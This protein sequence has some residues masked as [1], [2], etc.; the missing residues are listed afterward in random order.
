MTIKIALLG[1]WVAVLSGVALYPLVSLFSRIRSRYGGKSEKNRR[2]GILYE[3][4]GI[5]LYENIT[6]DPSYYL[7]RDELSIFQEYSDEIVRFI[8]E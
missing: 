1:N 4:C 3:G 8:L 6:R 2:P 7:Y 5:D